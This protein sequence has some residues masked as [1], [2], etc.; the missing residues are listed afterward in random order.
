MLVSREPQTCIPPYTEKVYRLKSAE[1]Y[2]KD[3]QDLEKAKRVLAK[4]QE[5]FKIITSQTTGMI[6]SQ[7]EEYQNN[8]YQN[9]QKGIYQ[10]KEKEEK[11]SKEE[12]KVREEKASGRYQDKLKFWETMGIKYDSN[13]RKMNKKTKLK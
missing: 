6:L 12:S 5:Q 1:Q 9:A 4:N 10:E 3:R 13:R 7:C 11:E 2:E 8:I